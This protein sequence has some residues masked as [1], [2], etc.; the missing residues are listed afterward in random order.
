MDIGGTVAKGYEKVRDAFA[1]AQSRDE[2]GAQLC[3]YRHGRVVVDLWGGQDPITNRAYS[4]DTIS[5]V[6]SCT[7]G[8]VAACAHILA[9]RGILDFDAPVARYW[10][11]FSQNG[12]SAITVRQ[13]FSHS[14][15][16]M[17]LDPE[18]GLTARDILDSQKYTKA[19]EAMAPLWKP[20][21]AYFY[22]FVS[23]GSLAGEIIRRITGLSVG[24][25]F[26]E[27]IAKPLH[28]DMWIGLPRSEEGRAAPH[29][30]KIPRL[31]LAEWKTSLAEMGMDLNSRVVKSLLHTFTTTDELID[32]M[33]T[34]AGREIELPAGNGMANA[35]ALAKMYASLIGPV[36]GVQLISRGAMESARKI[37]T[38]SLSAPDELTKLRRVD[39]QKF[40][41]GFELPYMLRPMSGPGSFGHSGAGGRLAY[42][43]PELELAVGYVCNTMLP[44]LA[45]PDPRWIG[46]SA[47]LETAVGAV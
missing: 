9:D 11:E 22:H 25:F 42:A 5:M 41:L 29:I 13:V 24:R 34:P 27:E 30:Q 15:G 20:G 32:V 26:A 4:S 10:P 1:S 33:N 40:G 35:R 16:L 23:F 18:S 44:D 19:L 6:M 8:A 12:K 31:S 45:G 43:N 21:T 38:A 14:A 2:G 47:E 39:A 36:D 37:Q 7:K 3:V 46:W 17:G 28:I